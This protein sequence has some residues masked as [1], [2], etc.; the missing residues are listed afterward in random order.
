MTCEKCSF[1]KKD[2]NEYNPKG[3]HALIDPSEESK[4][5][6]YRTMPN[7]SGSDEEITVICPIC[8]YRWHI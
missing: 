4:P 5:D 1:T 6:F 3:R 2:R 7:D 8:G